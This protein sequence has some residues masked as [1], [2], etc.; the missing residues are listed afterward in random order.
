VKPSIE[1]GAGAACAVVS[2]APSTVAATAPN[3]TLRMLV[4]LVD[5]GGPRKDTSRPAMGLNI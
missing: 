2:A 3:I 4:L 1:A 5:R